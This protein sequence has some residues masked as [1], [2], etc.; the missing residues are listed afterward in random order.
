MCN[1]E[2][3]H[4]K[5]TIN[6]LQLHQPVYQLLRPVQQLLRPVQQLLQRVQQFH[7]LLKK[8]PKAKELK[9]ILRVRKED[10]MAKPFFRFKQFT[11]FHHRCAMKVGTDGVLL[12]A[13]TKPENAEKILDIGTGSGL[14][15]LMLAQKC[16]ATIH[17]IDIEPNAVQQAR[18]NFE[19][20]IWSERMN[21]EEISLQDFA[22]KSETKF[23]LIISNPPFFVNSLQ[24]P[25]KNRS[26]A[27]HVNELTHTDLLLCAKRLLSKTGRICLILPVN[28]GLLNI[29]FAKSNQLY[30]TKLVYVFPKP[31]TQAKRV[32]I[33][34]SLNPITSAISKLE[35]ETN[36]R[37]QYS[38]DFTKLVKDYYLNL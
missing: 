1:R 28:E 11:V 6:G 13:W 18:E 5:A 31:D 24:T 2:E 33:E 30:C 16:V 19:N 14:I 38:I 35:I 3:L 23:D 25:D 29:D 12:G 4:H 26:S 7:L 10:K 34:Y 9:Q 36:L 17:A 27:R 37:H 8:A 20:S 32:L 22:S 21:V 15:A